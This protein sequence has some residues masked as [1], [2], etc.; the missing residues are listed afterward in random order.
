[1]VPRYLPTRQQESWG[2]ESIYYHEWDLD[3][4]R[5]IRQLRYAVLDP[6]NKYLVPVDANTLMNS[7]LE[8]LRTLTSSDLSMISPLLLDGIKKNF[9]FAIR[10]MRN[11]SQTREKPEILDP[12]AYAKQKDLNDRIGLLETHLEVID[13]ALRTSSAARSVFK[14]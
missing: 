11:L 12:N 1:M 3:K 8:E 2:R 5:S 4:R 13:G 7:S 6:N 14:L 10:N 9:S